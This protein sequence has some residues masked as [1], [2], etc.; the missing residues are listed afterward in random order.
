MVVGGEGRASRCF[1]PVLPARA[2]EEHLAGA[3]AEA[4]SEGLAVVGQDLIGHPWRRI[5]RARASQVGEAAFRRLPG[6]PERWLGLRTEDEEVS[7]S[8]RPTTRGLPS[9]KVWPKCRYL[10]PAF[11]NR[12]GVRACAS[13]TCLRRSLDPSVSRQKGGNEGG[14]GDGCVGDTLKS[15]CLQRAVTPSS[16]TSMTVL[17]GLEISA[18]DDVWSASRPSSLTGTGWSRRVESPGSRPDLRTG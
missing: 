4:P 13:R 3:H 17:D 5:A 18:G 11:G 1:I 14:I 2:V 7:P 8:M 10:E 6:R 9:P 12:C 16:A 15:E